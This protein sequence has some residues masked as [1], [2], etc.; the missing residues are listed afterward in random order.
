MSGIVTYCQKIPHVI[1]RIVGSKNQC[2]APPNGHFSDDKIRNMSLYQK[3]VTKNNT[4]N[5]TSKKTGPP[6][7]NLPLTFYT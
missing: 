6:T 3:V 2:P 7:K 5:H 4:K 1:Y